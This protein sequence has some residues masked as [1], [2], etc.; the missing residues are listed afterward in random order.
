MLFRELEHDRF[1]ELAEAAKVSRDEIDRALDEDGHA[2]LREGAHHT[3]L[4]LQ[5]PVFAVRGWLK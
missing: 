1:C 3:M 5:M 2:K 4:I